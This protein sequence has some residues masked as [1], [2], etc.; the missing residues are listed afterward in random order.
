MWGGSDRLFACLVQSHHNIR[1][2]IEVLVDGQVEAVLYGKTVIDPV[3]GSKANWYDGKVSVTPNQIRRESDLS[4]VD[5]SEVPGDLSVSDAE[6]LFAPL[7]SEFRVWRGYQYWDATQGEIAAGTANEY[8]PCGTFV[9]N[10]ATMDWPQI[11]LHGYDRLWLLRGRFQVPWSVVSGTP[12]MTELEKLLRSKIPAGQADIEL[13][14]S[15]ATS[16]ALIWEQQDDQLQRANDLAI[17]DGKIL[18]ADPMGTIRAVDPPVPSQEAVVWTFEPGRSNISQT[19]TRDI[20]ATDAENV[21]VASGETDGGSPP[22]FGIAKDTN[23]ASFTYVGKTPEIARFYSS[24][25]LKTQ[26]QCTR[27]AQAILI[28]ELGVADSIVVPTIPVPAFEWGDVI[29]VIDDKIKA[30]D[31]LLIDSFDIPLRASGTT[32]IICR[33]QRVKVGDN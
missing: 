30:N 14:I 33:S 20:D 26:L 32:Q 3:R 23:P 12:N 9:I 28:R 8:W 19:P 24:P 13:P 1:T 2:K 22:V 11:A 18:Y 25:L 6:D 31:L 29:Q 7:R 16:P 27:T 21:V 4:I 17:A 5:L 15:D 10:K